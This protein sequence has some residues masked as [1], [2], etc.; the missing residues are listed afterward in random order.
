[1]TRFREVL[2]ERGLHAA[3]IVDDRNVRY[4]SGFAGEDSV[5]LITPHEH[6]LL[7]DFR[8]VQEAAATAK[9]WT[10]VIEPQGLMEK[11]GAMARKSHVKLLAI[12][13]GAMRLTDL[14]PLRRAIGKI[15]LKQ[16]HAMVAELRLEKS[17]WEVACIE[18]ALRIQER[19]FA[20]VF[21]TLESGI[22]ERTIAAALRHAMV[23]AGADDQA[24][25]TMVQIGVNSSNPHGRPTRSVLKNKSAVLVDW[26]VRLCGYHSD[27]TRTFFWGKIPL[28]LRQLHSVVLEAHSALIARIAPGVALADLDKAAHAVID[29]AGHK[30]GFCHSTGHGIGL[31]IHEYPAISGHAKGSVREGMVLALEPGV[32]LPG[33]AGIRVEDMV[34]VTRNGCRVLSKLKH[35]LRWDGSGE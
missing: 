21:A 27:L 2:S 20:S 14:P 31:S 4:L 28:H 15:R 34:L 26:G 25:E 7:T 19:A 8:F 6:F 24:F 5:L 1:M 11:A 17:A 3:L 29:K 18:Q 32:Y 22:S 9:G 23:T 12:E 33:V 30:A 16:E 10:V 35:G 13:P